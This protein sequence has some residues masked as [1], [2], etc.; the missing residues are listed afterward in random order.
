MVLGCCGRHNIK[1]DLSSFKRVKIN[2]RIDDY[3]Y[4]KWKV[5]PRVLCQIQLYMINK[6]CLFGNFAISTLAEVLENG[7]NGCL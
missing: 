3:T 1:H 2:I 5:Q 6:T 4:T 7:K